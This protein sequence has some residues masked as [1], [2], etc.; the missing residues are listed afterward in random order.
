MT[1]ESSGDRKIDEID[2][3]IFVVTG[4]LAAFSRDQIE[5]LIESSGG[6][7]ASSVS[8]KTDYVLAGVKAG[9]KLDRAKELGVEVITEKDF[10]VLVGQE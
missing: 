8:R 4:T 9:S 3:K 10:L 1:D 2:G 5:E 7:V 6:R